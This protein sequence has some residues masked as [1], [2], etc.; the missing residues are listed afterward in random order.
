MI[1]PKLRFKA[2][3][4]SQFPDWEE[5]KMGDITSQYKVRNKKRLPLEIYSVNNI[6]GF[7][8]QSEQFDDAGYLKDTDTSIYMIVPPRHFAYNPARLDIGS[9]GYQYLDHDVQVSSL[10]EVFET[11]DLVNDEFLWS[12]FHTHYFNNVVKRLQEGGVRLYFY[13]DK[14]QEVK[15]GLPSLPEQ[16]KIAEFLSMIDTVIAKQKETVS[17]WEERKK[18]VM[19]KLFSQE[20]RFKADDGND[21]PEWE[22]KKLGEVGDI[23]TGNTPSTKQEDY[24]GGCYLWV[25]PADIT[26]SREVSV[27]AK[28]LTEL[29][30]TV[31]RHIPANSVLVTCI[32]SIGKNAIIRENGSCNQQINSITPYNDYS[33]EFVY[34][35]ICQNERL[36]HANAGTGGMEILNKDSFSKIKMYFPCLEE[37]QKIVDCLSSLDEVIA[38]QK[39]T[40]AAWEELKKGLLQQM[41]V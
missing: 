25:T 27:T 1:E 26:D 10:Y 24:Y 32:A 28:K 12:W 31:A 2:D 37:Q 34:Y 14:M 30:Y 7:I 9:I 41:F 40:L 36:L 23:M 20:A 29:G 8:P 6:V 5:K 22:E 16:Q 21:F 4:G 33:V 13:Y 3:D 15:I 35:L 18:G 19:Q 17:A 11:S 39:A 38:K